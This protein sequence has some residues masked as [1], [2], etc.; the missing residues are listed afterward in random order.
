MKKIEPVKVAV[1]IGR[2]GYKIA[3]IRDPNTSQLGL[4]FQIQ[5]P[6]LE[7]DVVP[8]Y[9]FM[10]AFEQHIQAPNKEY[11]YLLFAAEPYETI[12]FKVSSKEINRDDPST[13]FTHWNPDTRQYYFQFLFKGDVV[14]IPKPKMAV[15]RPAASLGDTT[16]AM[17]H[18]S[19]E[20]STGSIHP[21]RMQS[22]APAPQ[23]GDMMPRPDPSAMNSAQSAP[24]TM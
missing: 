6:K 5:Y 17:G 4:L 11:Q 19:Y 22:F 13:F 9:R 16:S 15:P 23:F 10:S 21:S 1:K 7:S 3:K 8:R 2:P 14:K 12:A 18:R 20:K 24:G